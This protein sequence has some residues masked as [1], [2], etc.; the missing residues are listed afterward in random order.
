MT[1]Q[2]STWGEGGG[3][4]K[5]VVFPI[6]FCHFPLFLKK[7]ASSLF[8]PSQTIPFSSN[9]TLLRLLTYPRPSPNSRSL[10]ANRIYHRKTKLIEADSFNNTIITFAVQSSETDT[11]SLEHLVKVHHLTRLEWFLNSWITLQVKLSKICRC[12]RR[13]IIH[14][15][16]WQA[17]N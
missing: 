1:Q 2:R 9:F 5:I 8:C 17:N 11:K 14:C 3:H 6:L 12:N 10:W 15:L 13:Q 16:T 7:L 4:Q